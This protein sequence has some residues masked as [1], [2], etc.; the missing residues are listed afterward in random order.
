M[1]FDGAFTF[2]H[3]YYRFFDYLHVLYKTLLVLM[4]EC[5]TSYCSLSLHGPI[6]L[7]AHG[8]GNLTYILVFICVSVFSS[9]AST[10]CIAST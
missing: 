1:T 9:D 3:S 5:M 4:A 6:S 7:L 2:S 8:V 10:N